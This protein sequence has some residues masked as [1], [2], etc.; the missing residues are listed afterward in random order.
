LSPAEED[1]LFE[2]QDLV[3]ELNDQIAEIQAA[4]EEAGVASPEQ[5][6]QLQTHT[7][8]RNEAQRTVE[9]LEAKRDRRS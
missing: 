9:R 5:T 3:M 1:R 6:A 8:R 2:A 4:V 7:T